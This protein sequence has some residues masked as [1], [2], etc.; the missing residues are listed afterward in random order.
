MTTLVTG[1]TGNVGRQVIAQLLDASDTAVRAV[2]RNPAAAGLPDGVVAVPADLAEPES[3]DGCLRGVDAVFLMWPLHSG[4]A[5]PAVLDVIK[6]HA[7]R[8]VFLGSGG[9]RDLT[10]DQQQE[11]IAQSGLEWTAIRP[12]TFA[13]NALWWAEQIRAGD[14]VRGVYGEL[15]MAMLHEADIAAVAVQA[16]TSQE[17][18]GMAHHLTGP[19]VISQAE[20]VRIIGEAIGRPLHWEE[21][22]RPDARQQMINDGFPL[23]F[24]D[25][26]LD[27]YAMMMTWPRPEVTSAVE[28]VTGAPART[29]RQWAADHAAAF[30]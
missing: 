11:L 25:V 21:V 19:Q 27:T 22:S 29:F 24:V 4:E 6:R 3:L 28:D 5:L 14:V 16:L 30:E 10:M 9:V 18:A 1:A 2:T 17:H 20:Q 8:V 12:S 23:S 13:V 7:H 26:L 15:G